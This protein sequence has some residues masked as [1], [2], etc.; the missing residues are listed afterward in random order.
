MSQSDENGGPDRSSASDAV[1]QLIRER[2]LHGYYP[3][4]KALREIELSTE[5]SFSRTPVREALRRLASQGLVDFV[6]NKGAKVATWRQADLLQIF[7]LRANLEGY[8]AR[9]AAVEITDESIGTLT[10]IS[11]AMEAA[12]MSKSDSRADVL[13]DLNDTFHHAIMSSSGDGRIAGVTEGIQQVGLVWLTFHR[14]TAEQLERSLHHH[15]ELIHAFQQHDPDW[16]ESVMRC[17]IFAAR[18]ALSESLLLAS[19]Y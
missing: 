12:A 9:R 17:H 6:P 13:S 10:A 16:A 4:G 19:R 15:R 7:I 1:Y 11:R 5:L 8:A 14:Y 3:P 2:L 18:S